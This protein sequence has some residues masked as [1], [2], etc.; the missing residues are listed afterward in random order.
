M[1]VGLEI[2]FMFLYFKFITLEESASCTV[3]Y[4]G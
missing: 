1:K 2:E 3:S 4:L